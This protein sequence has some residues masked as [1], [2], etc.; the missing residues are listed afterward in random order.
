MSKDFIIS[1]V[2]ICAVVGTTLGMKLTRQR[3]IAARKACIH[4]LRGMDPPTTT[5]VRYV[6]YDLDGTNDTKIFM[7]PTSSA[8]YIRLDGQWAWL[9]DGY[10]RGEFHTNAEG[11]PVAPRPTHSSETEY[12]FENG[13]WTEQENRTIH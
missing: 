9:F 12:V 1:L 4:N 8:T 6:D 3:E 7:S 11:C 5:S 10:M 13:R 2:L